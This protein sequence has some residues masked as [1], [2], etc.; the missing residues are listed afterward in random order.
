LAS[1]PTPALRRK[2]PN[3]R[4]ATVPEAKITRYL[5]D[6]AHP[7]GGSKAVFFLRFGFTVA[8]WERLAWSL[9][10]HAIENEVSEAQENRHGVRYAVDGPLSAPDGTVLN[11]RT[12]WFIDANS[13][14][15]R[16][17]T[18]HPLPKR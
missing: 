9:R 6:P 11:V 15:P 8:E 18:A 12:A 17:V 2:L 1:F 7:V 16:F 14:T 10:A 13:E 3:A 5:L 4:A